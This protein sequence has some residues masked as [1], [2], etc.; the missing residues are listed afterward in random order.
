MTADTPSRY[1]F[2]RYKIDVSRRLVIDG[3]GKIL[4]LTSKVF[5]LL[6]FLVQ[7]SGRT[8]SKDEIMATVWADT[9]VEESNL[10]QNISILRRALGDARGGNTFIATVSGRGYKFV[11]D[12]VAESHTPAQPSA[13]DAEPVVK[14]IAPR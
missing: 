9:V 4:P 12:V 3:E 2:G 13:S 10:T 7:N 1:R 11:A 6:L 8:V 5:D 14:T